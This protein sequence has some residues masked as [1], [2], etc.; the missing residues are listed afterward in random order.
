MQTLNTHAHSTLWTHV[1]KPYPYEH[2]QKTIL[3]HLEINEVTTDAS[4]LMGMSP[5]TES[6]TLLNLGINLEKCEHLCQI[7]DLNSGGRF[8]HK[9]PNQLS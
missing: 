2:L 4:L 6:I 3:A 7:E 5:I 1:R 9:E 8:H